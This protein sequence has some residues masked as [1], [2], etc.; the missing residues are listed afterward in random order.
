MGSAAIDI[1]RE[2]RRRI[3]ADIDRFR[4]MARLQIMDRVEADAL[5]AHLEDELREL[6]GQR[7]H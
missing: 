4:R 6:N 7:G 1:R 2:Q 5:I 3:E